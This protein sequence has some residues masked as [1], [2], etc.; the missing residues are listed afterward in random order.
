MLLLSG[1]L[2]MPDNDYLEAFQTI[3]AAIGLAIGLFASVVKGSA[4][5]IAWWGD[6]TPFSIFFETDS[7]SESALALRV[8][9]SIARTVRLTP[10]SQMTFQEIRVSP[11]RKLAYFW[12]ANETS[13]AFSVLYVKPVDEN[14]GYKPTTDQRGGIWLRLSSPVTLQG[15]EN[16]LFEVQMDASRHWTGDLGFSVPLAGGRRHAHRKVQVHN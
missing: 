14:L 11:Q 3:G 7:S 10:R 8:D 1:L 16:M 12:H 15:G 6:R 9:D 13:G 5:V 4:K 2:L